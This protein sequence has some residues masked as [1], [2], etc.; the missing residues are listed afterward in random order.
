MEILDLS[1]T[2]ITLQNF[3]EIANRINNS[4]ANIL[5]INNCGLTDLS[6]NTLF[7]NINRSWDYVSA[8]SNDIT[9]MGNNITTVILSQKGK[10]FNFSGNKI[11][12]EIYQKKYENDNIVIFEFIDIVLQ[13][14]NYT[15][16]VPTMN[17]NRDI[18]AIDENL[19]TFSINEKILINNK[20][21]T[22]Y[23]LFGYDIWKILQ[24]LGYDI[25]EYKTRYNEPRIWI[26]LYTFICDL[27]CGYINPLQRPSYTE[28]QIPSQF[29]NRPLAKKLY[30]YFTGYSTTTRDFSTK[31]IFKKRTVY[32]LNKYL[33]ARLLSN[34]YDILSRPLYHENEI[35]FPFIVNLTKKTCEEIIKENNNF[36]IFPPQI[37]TLEEKKNYYLKNLKDYISY[38]VRDN[39]VIRDFRRIYYFSDSELYKYFPFG[40]L[41]W[42]SRI[43][44]I[45]KIEKLLD[46]TRPIWML[47]NTEENC[48]NPSENE[49]MGTEIIRDD[50]NNPVI[51]YGV[52][53][54]Y[55]CYN[56]DTLYDTW[57]PT[58]K[59]VIQ[60]VNNRN[61]EYTDPRIPVN[62]DQYQDEL[63]FFDIESLKY[64]LAL[65]K[66][67]RRVSF[68][69]MITFLEW[70]IKENKNVNDVY[71]TTAIKEY[72]KNKTDMEKIMLLSF[73]MG[74]YCR[75]WLGFEATSKWPYFYSEQGQGDV[76]IYDNDID[77][78]KNGE[79]KNQ[80]HRNVEVTK[81]Y[82]EIMYILEKN[83]ELSKYIPQINFV[84][85]NWRD[86]NVNYLNVKWYD[87]LL[88]VAKANMCLAQASDL[89]T[90]HAYFFVKNIFKWN[91]QTFN[92]KIR[93]FVVDITNERYKEI[94]NKKPQVHVLKDFVPE[95]MNGSRHIDP[96]HHIIENQNRDIDVI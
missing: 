29:R 87:I 53:N 18:T 19:L 81:Y 12:K 16:I 56:L 28:N 59:L 13:R 23:L 15:S 44:L 90:K 65:L 30:A 22:D 55:R 58:G 33:G 3:K 31:T 61:P 57:V 96:H 45:T 83:K 94:P 17:I 66:K 24:L 76:L 10:V 82:S 91:N 27:Y 79:V 75:F 93:K 67:Y 54:M 4:L 71:I 89:Y 39:T 43:D 80:V 6:F 48:V 35:L 9:G 52:L 69:K 7:K 78:D 50:I 85:Y 40:G 88:E 32:Q 77:Y 11:T 46:N 25:P 34:K 63:E 73:L 1:N 37:I 38:F 95:E 92:D 2:S 42:T 5:L 20:Y 70:Y 64:L 86:G 47:I 8:I 84:N 68:E 60:E 36:M 26:E 14:T 51:S 72:E 21:A 74:M 49:I 62:E 41:E